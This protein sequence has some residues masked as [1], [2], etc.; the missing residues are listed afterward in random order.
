MFDEKQM[1]SNIWFSKNSWMTGYDK[2]SYI[3]GIDT[4]MFG[5]L[6]KVKVTIG[7]Q[8]LL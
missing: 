6:A 3:V 7:T 2:P 8:N 4:A 5:S 1:S